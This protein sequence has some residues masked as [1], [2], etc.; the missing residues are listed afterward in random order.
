MTA[1]ILT[2]LAFDFGEKHIGIAV[3]Q[4]LTGS[5][6]ALAPSRGGRKPD[7]RIIDQCV[8]TW[9]PDLLV[10]GYPLNM[11][12]TEQRLSAMSSRFA[13]QLEARYACEVIFGD[14]RLSTVAARERM[15]E[16]S[17]SLFSKRPPSVHSVAAE[18]I[19]ETW[20]RHHHALAS[21]KAQE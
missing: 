7:W 17:A 5:A 1:E 6:S 19:F 14:E 2:V 9:Q 15:V 12:G 8:S 13:R 16:R 20:Y 10:I 4:T 11:D 21:R 18:I 3:G